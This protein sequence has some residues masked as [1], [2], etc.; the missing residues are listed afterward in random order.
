MSLALFLFAVCWFGCSVLRRLAGAILSTHAHMHTHTH[1]SLVLFG[2][3]SLLVLLFGITS[4]DTSVPVGLDI[5]V[6]LTMHFLLLAYLAMVS[7]LQCFGTVFHAASCINL[8]HA[9]LLF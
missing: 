5:A 6:T 7:R 9:P 2:I 4:A 3:S 8:V 1:S